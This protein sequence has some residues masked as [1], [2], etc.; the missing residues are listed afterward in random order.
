VG[1]RGVGFDEVGAGIARQ[2]LHWI[3]VAASQSRCT[4]KDTHEKDE[5]P[6]A[7]NKLPPTSI[8]GHSIGMKGLVVNQDMI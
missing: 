7:Q 3:F 1:E 4:Y 6:H 2:A 5:L 8:I